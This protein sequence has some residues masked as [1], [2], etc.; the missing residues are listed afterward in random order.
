[1]SVEWSQ[2]FFLSHSLNELTCRIKSTLRLTINS[3]STK[4]SCAD[5]I[6][7][8]VLNVE[9]SLEAISHCVTVRALPRLSSLNNQRRSSVVAVPVPVSLEL[10]A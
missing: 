7:L 1:M 6:P 2:V 10:Q 5:D 8:S 4:C 9:L 3:T